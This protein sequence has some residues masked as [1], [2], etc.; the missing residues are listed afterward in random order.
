[1]G[2]IKDF[3]DGGGGSF[4]IIPACIAL[5]IV[6]GIVECSKKGEREGIQAEA[7]AR[8]DSTRLA[9][10]VEEERYIKQID[11]NRRKFYASISK[12][13]SFFESYDG[14]NEWLDEF[15]S[16]GAI[17]LLHYTFSQ[18]YDN[19]DGEDGVERMIGYLGWVPK[20]QWVNC[21]QCD[22]EFEIEFE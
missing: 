14:F 12:Y 11:S 18:Y 13:C 8:Y 7:Q 10:K 2:R 17:E 15:S 16:I 3:F 9:K 5:G 19:F 4:L 21:P 6:G 1:M 22:Y 20:I